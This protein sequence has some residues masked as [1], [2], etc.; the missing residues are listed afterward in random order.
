[1]KYAL[2]MMTL[3][4]AQSAVAAQGFYNHWKYETYDEAEPPYAAIIGYEEGVGHQDTVTTPKTIV[5]EAKT[6]PV[7]EI[8]G[9]NGNLDCDTL[10]VSGDGSLKLG[11]HAFDD[12]A[13]CQVSI[14]GV[15]DVGDSAFR[16]WGDYSKLEKVTFL[17]QLVTN[18]D[19]EAFVNCKKLKTI[20]IPDSVKTI[21]ESAFHGAGIETID[22]GKGVTNIAQYAFWGC[23]KLKEVEFPDSLV[24]HGNR[25]FRD[26]SALTSLVYGS[27]LK[28]ITD[29]IVPT[30]GESPELDSVTI[31]GDGTTVI[32][33]GTFR[34]QSLRRLTVSGVAEIGESAFTDCEN[35]ATVTFEGNALTNLGKCAFYR[36][37]AL[38]EVAV[39]D[40]VTVLGESVF[41]DCSSL[42]EV[43][44]GAGVTMLPLRIVKFCSELKVMKFSANLGFIDGWNYYVDELPRAVY[45]A[46][47]VPQIMKYSQ[48]TNDLPDVLYY[49]Y[50]A[51]YDSPVVV[52]AR[53]RAE[54]W[55]A[56]KQ[57]FPKITRART[58]VIEEPAPTA[59]VNWTENT[60][61]NWK[62][63]PGVVPHSG[64]IDV[65]ELWPS[66]TV[67][68]VTG[69]ITLPQGVTLTVKPGAIVKFCP[70]TGIYIQKG[71]KCDM[72]GVTLTHIADDLVGGDTDGVDRTPVRKDYA[73]VE[74][75]DYVTDETTVDRYN[76]PL[77]EV[78]GMRV[79]EHSSPWGNEYGMFD[80]EVDLWANDP[81]LALVVEAWPPDDKLSEKDHALGFK[82][83]TPSVGKVG[84]SLFRGSVRFSEVKDTGAYRI[85]ARP[86]TAAAMSRSGWPNVGSDYELY[87][88]GSETTLSDEVVVDFA[89]PHYTT[90]PVELGYSTF[91]Y[92]GN[93]DELATDVSIEIKVGDTVLYNTATPAAGK[94]IWTP[95]PSFSGG[96]R[97]SYKATGKRGDVHGQLGRPF[98][99]SGNAD[100]IVLPSGTE[101]HRGVV[102]TDSCWAAGSVHVVNGRID[103]IGGATL[104]IAPG[105]VVKFTDGACIQVADDGSACDVRGA[106]LTHI[107][108]ASVGG[109]SLGDGGATAPAFGSY[110]L[111]GN[112]IANEFTQY[113][114][115]AQR[116]LVGPIAVDTTL[117]AGGVYVVN[118]DVTVKAGA[119]LTIQEGTVV[120]FADGR[121]LVVDGELEVDG[122]RNNPVVFTSIKHDA[123]GGDTNGDADKTSPNAG[124][125]NTVLINGKAHLR[126][127]HGYYGAPENETGIFTLS[128]NDKSEMVMEGCTIANAK[129]D[130]V[131]NWG[132]TLTIVNCLFENCGNAVCP[133]QGT[134]TCDNSLIRYCQYGFMDWP[135]WK[136]GTFR[137]CIFYHC[138]QGWSDTNTAGMQ[139]NSHSK[140]SH[141]CFYNGIDGSC[142]LNGV[143]GCIYADPGLSLYGNYVNMSPSSPCIDAGDGSVA[144][145][146]DY[147]GRPR[148]DN[149]DVE[150]TGVPNADGICP[151]IGPYEY[152][153]IPAGEVPDLAVV[154][155]S[156]PASASAG[157]QIEV[158]Y[159][160]ANRSAI[161]AVAD[162]TDVVKFCG[163]DAELAGIEVVAG[164]VTRSCNLKGGETVECTAT[165]AVPPL[166]PGNWKVRVAANAGREIYELITANNIGDAAA[167]T[168]ITLPEVAAGKSITVMLKGNGSA[169][170]AVTGLSADGAVVF[171]LP[172][173]VRAYAAIGYLPDPVRNDIE[174]VKLADGRFALFIPAHAADAKVY[175]TL[176]ES[177]GRDQSVKV[178]ALASSEGLARAKPSDVAVTAQGPKV[179]ASLITPSAI[180]DGRVYAAYVEYANV[181]NEDAELPVFSV[182]R[183]DDDGGTQFSKRSDGGFSSEAITLV[184]LAPSAPRGKLKPGESGRV[185]FF[186]MTQDRLALEL[187]VMGED[188]VD[189]LNG[190]ASPSAYAAGMSAAASRLCERGSGD[191]DFDEVLGQA[192]NDKRGVGGGSVCGK[193]CHLMTIMPIADC[194]LS[195][196][197]TNDNCVVS[198]AV[199]DEKG[200][201][202]LTA[203]DPGDYVIEIDG[204]QGHSR[205][206]YTIGASDILDQ[207]IA[208]LPEAFVDGCVFVD[209]KPA[210]QTRVTLDDLDTEEIEDNSMLT[211]AKGRFRFEKVGD[212]SYRLIAA[213]YNGYRDLA[214]GEITVSGGVGQTVD[215]EYRELGMAVTC[216]VK[217]EDGNPF[218]TGRLVLDS[219]GRKYV[220]AIDAQG[221]CVIDGVPAGEY[222]LYL[223]SRDWKVR[224]PRR[225]TVSRG[226]PVAADVVISEA[227]VATVT[228]PY[229]M[230][231]TKN[232][233]FKTSVDTKVP[234]K[235]PTWYTRNS[236][237]SGDF[238][239]NPELTFSSPG[240]YDIKVE[241]TDANGNRKSCFL[242]KA[243]TV[244]E[245]FENVLQDNG[246]LVDGTNLKVESVTET[247]LVVSGTG[248]TACKKGDVVGFEGSEAMAGFV[249][250]LDTEP[251]S[252]SGGK[253]RFGTSKATLDDLWK[254]YFIKADLQLRGEAVKRQEMEKD[255]LQRNLSDHAKK[256]WEQSLNI[257]RLLS[258]GQESITAMLEAAGYD[259]YIVRSYT[260]VR[261]PN[262]VFHSTYYQN[263][264]WAV[265]LSLEVAHDYLSKNGEARYPPRSSYFG[266]TVWQNKVARRKVASVEG[267]GWVLPY[268]IGAGLQF[269][270]GGKW[271]VNG[272]GKAGCQKSLVIKK[273]A[274][275]TIDDDDP[276]Y[277]IEQ[278]DVDD[279]PIKVWASG[280]ISA[281][282]EV[283]ATVGLM[284]SWP[285]V[286]TVKAGYVGAGVKFGIPF[287]IEQSVSL[288]T[289][290]GYDSQL[291]LNVEPHVCPYG[292]AGAGRPGGMFALLADLPGKVSWPGKLSAG[293]L[294]MD[295]GGEGLDI[296]FK[297]KSPKLE[298]TGLFAAL[299]LNELELSS[300]NHRWSFGDG[301]TGAGE[302]VAHRYPER[303]VYDVRLTANCPMPASLLPSGNG[304][305][306]LARVAL[307]KLPV[308]EKGPPGPMKV[309]GVNWVNPKKSVDPNEIAGPEGYGEKRLVEPGQWMNYTIYFENKSTAEAPAQEI[310]VTNQLSQ[311][312]DWST[313][314]MLD[315]GFANQVET[316]LAGQQ[317]AQ[318]L[319]AQQGVDCK[320]QL[321]VSLDSE[322]GVA[323]WYLRS[324][325]MS[326]SDFGY[327]PEDVDV[328]VLPPNDATHRGE[329]YITYR[330]KVRADAPDD[331]RIDNTAT[332]VFDRNAPIETD[333]AWWNTVG[334]VPVV[335]PDPVNPEPVNPDPVSPDPVS[336]DP[337]SPDPVT[338]VNPGPVK[339]DPVKPDPVKYVPPKLFEKPDGSAFSGNATYTGW[340]R[341][342]NGQI[343]GTLT[344]KAAKPGKD[345]RAK[346]SGSYVPFGGKKQSIKG[347]TAAVGEIAKVTI[348]GVGEVTLG[349]RAVQSAD[350]RVQLAVDGL[351]SKDKAEKAAASERLKGKAGT[352]TFALLTEAGDVGCSVTV[353]AKGKAKLQGVLPDG[354]KVSVS[355]QGVLGEQALAIPFV[356]AK[357]GAL[358]LV[359]WLG[360]DGKVE[361]SDLSP[362]KTAAGA[363]LATTSVPPSAAHAL[364]GGDHVF[365]TPDFTQG[366]TV[367]GKKWTAPKQNKKLDPDPNPT[368]LKLSFA[369]KTGLVKGSY[370]LLAADGKKKLKYTVNGAVVGDKFYGAAT[371][372]KP[373]RS[374]P[375]TTD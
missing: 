127:C 270:A 105:A 204:A 152:D 223:D 180:R 92:S 277:E 340:V 220:G 314:E 35:L 12:A 111:T 29:E 14:A 225:I 217:G 231:G 334:K 240:K 255:A 37:R 290:K 45:F 360:D 355:V 293:K 265:K 109:D 354:A 186:I 194:R 292:T 315:I 330:V 23:G 21:G 85:T 344:L 59:G 164:S 367:N 17:D 308:Y 246:H 341:D 181:G 374:V 232:K 123:F 310:Q 245:E 114:Y 103:V 325:D 185:A 198:V 335:D 80:V 189:N 207:K 358:G 287:N 279:D 363:I 179:V 167:T 337:V 10:V 54:S 284:L 196:V 144:P 368:G 191:P 183:A 216:T 283:F 43:V 324:Y 235:D 357:K 370:T 372:K 193:V 247:E 250:R 306:G 323:S 157:D 187:S 349:A 97:F 100:F 208:V 161:D 333:P 326:Q 209:G 312:L 137:N 16:G 55:E 156:A 295:C 213:A 67:H 188:S 3:A 168:A 294:G 47:E 258:S 147:Y 291:A 125:W 316:A 28:T 348:P 197:R 6:Y 91:W 251:E 233:T 356:Y 39:P 199:S 71:A 129:Y 269:Q 298:A 150:D 99:R 42:R 230:T 351:K 138:S 301:G 20:R 275:I 329:G 70:G 346:L 94:V 160:V 5:H 15:V 57:T 375:A 158:V 48:L 353:N 165:V 113:R 282:V 154:S 107:A 365:A 19:Y 182:A 93:A 263:E 288:D 50:D 248:A 64:T 234:L 289:E 146:M 166:A 331:A 343:A 7:R 280:S 104:T 159:T 132:G 212:G 136:G 96:I 267:P 133:Y 174:D 89:N 119:K 221:G 40:S 254:Q 206:V 149:P 155:V 87:A 243:V 74:F 130:G 320:V 259:D 110:T 1:M 350:G 252:L 2:T 307:G 163:A 90:G 134:T 13:I 66:G 361:L 58:K 52:Y 249:N 177:M 95:E 305:W 145:A 143:N 195:L 285:A 8:R 27:G 338:P 117:P 51:R 53:G 153:G 317:N 60:D 272:T 141:C 176:V 264:V 327:W 339:P 242:D 273:R 222:D 371:L 78:Y 366:F 124:D 373:P 44:F 319:V 332:I 328:G 63:V 237:S 229:G 77:M 151:D 205:T 172:D 321:N 296:E 75:G 81:E 34:S 256:V 9:V 115:A 241:Y 352:W 257:G 46:G 190:F 347:L 304:D 32:E 201:F 228:K 73:I 82:E 33:S 148:M 76:E 173:G 36:C 214:S 253:I 102:S 342:A 68:V 79:V 38:K 274:K 236:G 202:S 175:V 299:G 268:G 218:T 322:T 226:V 62:S 69:W 61:R 24:S 219:S 303:G 362:V 238:V 30:I 106:L 83:C 112:I 227:D 244:F 162:L 84:R 169:G 25:L 211:D 200:A 108:D 309:V 126:Y 311:Y 178:E 278:W 18:I 142:A 121:K 184:G 192:L 266:D 203:S 72:R 140:V 31:R 86:R 120:K 101:L 345:G 302:K 297:A 224:S 118:D 313:F 215:L 239:A 262:G 271:T 131:W 11:Y 128:K 364:A 171:S 336:P 210:A 369:E 170:L 359:L 65:N 139:F 56:W 122:M 318:A 26:C 260:A 88:K 300:S 49:S 22:F 4:I 261:D 276:K 135:A 98:D 286:S 116:T 41:E 281:G